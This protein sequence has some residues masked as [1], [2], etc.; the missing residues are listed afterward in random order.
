MIIFCKGRFFFE[1]NGRKQQEKNPSV[2][3][4]PIFGITNKKITIFA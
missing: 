3:D 4:T 2:K 1:N